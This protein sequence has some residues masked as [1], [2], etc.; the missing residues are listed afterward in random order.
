MF[1]SQLLQQRSLYP[2]Y[3]SLSVP[4]DT[5]RIPLLS[6]ENIPEILI[7]ATEKMRFAKEVDGVLLVCPGPLALGNG[8]GTF[9]RITVY[10]YK[11]EVRGC[12]LPS[13]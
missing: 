6:M 5:S 12:Y 4:L 2:L 1:S 3:P 11:P 8:A 13:L 9:A 7:I 10:P